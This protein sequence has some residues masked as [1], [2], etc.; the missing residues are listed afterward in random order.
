MTQEFKEQILGAG[1]A[2]EGD[3]AE[4]QVEIAEG[5][6]AFSAG[7]NRAIGD[8]SP[9]S[10]DARDELGARVQRELLPYFLKARTPAQM[11]GKPRGYTGDFQ[12]AEMIRANSAEGEAPAG[13]LLD[14]AFLALPV[15][16]AL[17]A[18]RELLAKEMQRVRA[19][20]EGGVFRVVAIAAAPAP[21]LRAPF[22]DTAAPLRTEATLIEFDDEAL[23]RLRTLDVAGGPVRLELEM[24]LNL[25]LARRRVAV[26]QQDFAYALMLG[27]ALPDRFCIGLLNYLHGMLRPGG[28]AAVGCIHPDNPDKAFLDHVLGW[29]LH[30]R[31]ESD[32]HGLFRHSLFRSAAECVEAEESGIFFIASCQK[33]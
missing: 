19:E 7:L 23:A 30:H 26:E 27:N 13:A 20:V 12:T 3:A 17:R 33:V 9:E 2:A 22:P 10:L 11:Y 15:A 4:R 16:A 24:L 18:S 5:L 14:G 21:E 6:R 28:W 32:I 29:E 8:G 1:K 31:T 25:A